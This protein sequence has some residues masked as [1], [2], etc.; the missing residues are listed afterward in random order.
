MNFKYYNPVRIIF[1]NGTLSQTGQW[2]SQLGRRAFITITG[3]YFIENGLIAKIQELLAQ[4]GVESLC[5]SG[6]SPNPLTTEIDKAAA[7]ARQEGC[8]FVIGVG[9]GSAMDAAKGV[10]ISAT[11]EGGLWKYCGV[12]QGNSN[13]VDIQK[14]LPIL[15]ITTTSGTGSH[16]TPWAVFTNPETGEKPGMGG[17]FNFAKIAIVD[18]E[19]MISLPKRLTAATGFDVFAHAY[20]AYTSSLATPATDLYAIEAIRLVGQYLVRAVR[21][22]SDTQARSGMALADTYAG[23]ALSMAEVTLCHAMAHAVGGVCNAHHGEVLGI[24]AS[25]T[26]D[27]SIQ[28]LPE[29]FRKV[30][31]YLRNQELPANSSLQ[32]DLELTQ[33][34]LLKLRQDI[35]ITFGLASVGVTEDKLDEIAHNTLTV[36]AGSVA[37]DAHKA[38]HEDVVNILKKCM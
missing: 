10:A 13:P 20:E 29:K 38:T 17:D 4:N 25:A 30:G 5:Y 15:C 33:S 31:Y 35:G 16:V 9:G 22:G 3:S 27:F 36:T 1:G 32:E 21:D 2:A 12:G 18:P 24:M 11:H 28:H 34:E 37:N 19:L 26:T 7:L 23:V 14:V 6:I 8:D